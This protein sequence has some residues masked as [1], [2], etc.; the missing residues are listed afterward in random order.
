MWI[1]SSRQLSLSVASACSP[2]KASA[3]I[4]L[5]ASCILRKYSKC[6]RERAVAYST[7][8]LSI[9]AFTVTDL[10]FHSTLLLADLLQH[11]YLADAHPARERAVEID[12]HNDASGREG[13]KQGAT[14]ARCRQCRRSAVWVSA[15]WKGTLSRT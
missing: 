14:Q 1:E 8:S 4:T 15:L 6:S 13:G 12:G 3:T 5:I 11:L 2:R 10:R 7:I 9:E